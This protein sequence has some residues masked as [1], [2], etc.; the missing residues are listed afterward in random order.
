MAARGAR[1]A[2]TRVGVL[3]S[4]YS[5]TD[6]EGQASIAAFLDTFQRLSLA[7][8][9]EYRSW[10]ALCVLTGERRTFASSAPWKHQKIS[11][12]QKEY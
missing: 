8:L 1:A 7:M 12:A 5:Q 10:P 2:T 4:L 6:R 3:I 11:K 9:Q